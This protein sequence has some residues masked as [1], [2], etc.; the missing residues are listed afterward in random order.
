MNGDEH[1]ARRAEPEP[2]HRE[3]QER[4]RRQRI[5]HRRACREEVR[6][7]TL[8]A[9]PQHQRCGEYEPGEVA[10]KQGAHREPDLLKQ[11]AVDERRPQRRGRVGEPR[12]HEGF[13]VESNRIRLPR[14]HQTHENRS[15]A[16]P[17][18]IP[19]PIDPG[20]LAGGVA[21]LRFAEGL[22][23]KLRTEMDVW[24]TRAV[25]GGAHTFCIPQ[26]STVRSSRFLNTT[27][28]T[29]IPTR[30]TVNRPANTNGICRS[31]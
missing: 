10:D 17:V 21:D 31:I 4:D 20:E 22:D 15:L 5:E 9:R 14:D 16:H 13:D 12:E 11:I 24:A 7:N 19:H 3:R 1:D 6:A 18:D 25:R 8:H 30:I 2:Q 26:R 23:H 28:S 27:F 29:T